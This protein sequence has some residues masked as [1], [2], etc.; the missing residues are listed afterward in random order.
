MTDTALSP[1]Q[2]SSV[3]VET[4]INAS[5]DAVWRRLFHDIDVWWPEGFFAGGESG[6]RRL[7]LENQVGGRMYEEWDNGG[8]LLWGT[9]CALKPGQ[10]LQIVGHTFPDWG[11]PTQ[12]YGTFTL[13]PVDGGTRVRFLENTVGRVDPERLK[14]NQKGWDFLFCRALKAHVEGAPTPEW[15]D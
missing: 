11:G 9:L 8:G 3:T 1:A 5:P 14:D 12:W 2:I 7:I 15:V 4:H 6:K 13:E 10:L